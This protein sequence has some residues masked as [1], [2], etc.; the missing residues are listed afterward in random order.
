M[1]GVWL[2]F[3]ALSETRKDL[4][5]FKNLLGLQVKSNLNYY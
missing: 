1:G 5:G 4:T 2:Q 3:F